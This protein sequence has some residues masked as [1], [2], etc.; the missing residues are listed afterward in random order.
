MPVAV[1]NTLN[2]RID[3]S[4]TTIYVPL[5]DIE[6]NTSGFRIMR[7]VDGEEPSER[8]VPV[9]ECNGLLVAKASR[10]RDGCGIIVPS[11]K[12][13]LAL[14]DARVSGSVLCLPYG[15]VSLPLTVLPALERFTKLVLWFGNDVH[16][17]DI[18]RSFAKKLGEKRCYF[19]R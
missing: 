3:E 7:V 6:G 11:L 18:A 16:S 12:D 1:L 19:V 9:T 5:S 14:L 13:A 10:T 2:I 8:T 15:L 17:W 4:Q